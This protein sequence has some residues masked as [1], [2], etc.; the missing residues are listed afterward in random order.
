MSEQH[1]YRRVAMAEMHS[2]SIELV[3]YDGIYHIYFASNDKVQ[4]EWHNIKKQEAYVIFL[5]EI[6]A[7][8]KFNRMDTNSEDHILEVFNGKWKHATITVET[9]NTDLFELAENVFYHIVNGK[10]CKVF[11]DYGTRTIQN[12]GC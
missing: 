4:G 2:C 6:V 5:G 10:E 9:E 12:R 11:T 3:E 7:A 8:G 1:S